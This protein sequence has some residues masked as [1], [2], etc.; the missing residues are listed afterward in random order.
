MSPKETEFVGQGLGEVGEDRSEV[1][2]G[3]VRE[4]MGGSMAMG[5]GGVRVKG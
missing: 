5:K 1:A 4:T 2:N 3:G